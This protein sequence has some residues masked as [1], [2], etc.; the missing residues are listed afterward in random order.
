MILLTAAP[1]LA[2]ADE[3]ESSQQ[4]SL[5]Y[6]Q[7]KPSL[8]TNLSSGGRYVRCDIQ[9]MTHNEAYLKT[10][11]LHSPAIRH[12]LLLLLADQDGNRIKTTGG[13]ESL[14][15]AALSQINRLLKEQSGK[16]AVE[17]LFFTTFFV[18]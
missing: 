1:L 3:E 14:R 6:F 17:S 10:L 8:V 2:A 13:K 4:P 5:Y 16:G 12:T 7:L 11:R 15:K 18:Q 9:L